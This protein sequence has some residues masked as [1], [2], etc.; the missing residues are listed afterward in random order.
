MALST[1]FCAVRRTARR[2]V[3]LIAA[4]FPVVCT[5]TVPILSRR[6]RRAAV[7]DWV[8]DGGLDADVAFDDPSCEHAASSTDAAQPRDTARIRMQRDERRSENIVVLYPTT[9][10]PNSDVTVGSGR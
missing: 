2:V 8:D 7:A 3:G 4:F 9:R 5:S 6:V 10:H 1:Y